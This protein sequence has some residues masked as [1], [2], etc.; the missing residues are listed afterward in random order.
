MM[1]KRTHRKSR[2]YTAA[3]S[4]KM[5]SVE[6]HA[7]TGQAS[8]PS[9]QQRRFMIAEAAYYLAERR[10]FAPHNEWADWFDAEEKIDRLIQTADSRSPHSR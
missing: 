4:P 7:E 6:A 2:A 3:D 1:V 10:G 8:V 9:P 5:A